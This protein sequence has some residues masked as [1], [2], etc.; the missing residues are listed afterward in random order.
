MPTIVGV[1]SDR[2]D[3][4]KAIDQLV[5]R[6]LD[7]EALGVIW[8]ERTVA[9]PEEVKVFEY[10]DHFE[11]PAE[12][13]KKGAIG[14]A[15]GG[16]ASVGSIL[17]ASAGGFFLPE[18]GYLATAGAIAVVAAGAAGGTLT[19]TLIGAL[20]GAADHDAT[21]V[22]T[23]ETN[24]V[25]VLE[26]QGFVVTVDTGS[27]SED[28]AARAALEAVGATEITVLDESG[29]RRTQIEADTE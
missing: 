6:G 15:L 7:Q 1:F 17:L 13:A 18:L 24:Y 3:T 14:G 10:V 2:S 28:Q 21:K 23:T 25:D 29:R 22:T 12:E 27:E 26:R 9:K 5:K 11:G 8:R 20:L 4:E 16:T 19:G